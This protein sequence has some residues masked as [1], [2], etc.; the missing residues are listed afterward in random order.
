MMDTLT[1]LV[2][3]ART[4]VKASCG[5]GGFVVSGRSAGLATR[6]SRKGMA[7]EVNDWVV[8]PRHGVGRVVKCEMRQ[9]DSR[10]RQLHYQIALPT[11]TLWVP[12]GG[13]SSGLR[14]MTERG[15]LARYRGVLRGQ[16]IPLPAEH[17]ERRNVLVERV[18]EGS[19]QAWCEAVRDLSALGWSKALNES[20]SAM[21]RKTRGDL[22]TEWAAADGVSITQAMNEVET[23]LLDGRKAHES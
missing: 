21:L 3:R 11:G 19:F 13:A 7:I 10:D 22:C 5:I 20:D 16:P 4:A 17:R 8:H 9:F 23:A 18:S 6:E 2:S 15:E 12:V 14:K 1:Y